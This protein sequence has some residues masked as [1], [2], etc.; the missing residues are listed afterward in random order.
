MSLDP[1]VPNPTSA[2]L[3]QEK[4]APATELLNAMPV[5]LSPLQWVRLDTELTGGAGLTVKLMV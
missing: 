2:S 1:L 4:V 5:A 3:V